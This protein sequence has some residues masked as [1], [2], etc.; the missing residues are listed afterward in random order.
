MKSSSCIG[1]G[2]DSGLD[3]HNS[4]PVLLVLQLVDQ[5]GDIGLSRRA[6]VLAKQELEARLLVNGNARDIAGL[7]LWVQQRQTLAT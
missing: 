5:I 2:E 6:V 7:L 4:D 3:L 1:L